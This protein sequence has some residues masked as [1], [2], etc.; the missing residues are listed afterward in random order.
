MHEIIQVTIERIADDDVFNFV[1]IARTRGGD[2]FVDCI[3]EEFEVI[4]LVR[5]YVETD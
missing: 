1:V 2:T 5:G 3:R 4:E